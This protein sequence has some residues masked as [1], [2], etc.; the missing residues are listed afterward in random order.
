MKNDQISNNFMPFHDP[1]NSQLW[2]SVDA[3]PSILKKR[4]SAY[5]LSNL[6]PPPPPAVPVYDLPTRPPRHPA[7]VNSLASKDT[8]QQSRKPRNGCPSVATV[9]SEAVASWE[10]SSREST[11]DGHSVKSRSSSLALSMPTGP[12][13]EVTPW[14]LYPVPASPSS[15]KSLKGSDRLKNRKSFSSSSTSVHQNIPL[16]PAVHK[17]ALVSTGPVE[18]VTPWELLPGPSKD[19]LASPASPKQSLSPSLPIPRRPSSNSDHVSVPVYPRVTA[20]GPTEEVTP[21]E[22]TPV[23][24][25]GQELVI[26]ARV[27][28]SS[29]MA[30]VEDVTPWELYP[31][32]RLNGSNISG[33]TQMPLG[34]VSAERFFGSLLL[35][36]LYM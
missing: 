15:S 19:G 25:R 20:T 8:R 17:S 31:A 36:A 3:P 6:P 9:S 32:L 1:R 34:T 2:P 23:P 27:G 16:P 22:L 35:D 28:S 30:Q 10:G 11:G 18:E 21:W 13:E 29:R 5:S 24:T 4:H 12:V 14:E 33:Q 26:P 7:R